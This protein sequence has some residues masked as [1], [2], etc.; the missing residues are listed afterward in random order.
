MET[1]KLL[2]KVTAAAIKSEVAEEVNQLKSQGIIPG[3]A[4]V[5]V[6]EDPAS[7]MYVGS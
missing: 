3:L 4:T 5:L 2:G 1:R 7:E 6:G